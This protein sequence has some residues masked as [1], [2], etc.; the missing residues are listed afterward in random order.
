MKYT[1]LR[2]SLSTSLY[3]HLFN[4]LASASPCV[5][6]QSV[7][8]SSPPEFI[9]CHPHS[10]FQS[11]ILKSHR[12]N[13]FQFPPKHAPCLPGRS[14]FR[15]PLFVSLTQK[16]FFLFSFFL[17]FFLSFFD[18]SLSHDGGGRVHPDG[19]GPWSK[20]ISLWHVQVCRIA[21]RVPMPAARESPA[22]PNQWFWGAPVVRALSPAYV[23]PLTVFPSILWRKW[24][25]FDTTAAV[26]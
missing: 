14:T 22:G 17:F 16:P 18:L 5:L 25:S 8:L 21:S 15:C 20:M 9:P 23:V 2:E 1:C 11:V 3:F 6:K 10:L 4:G 7:D 24:L 19:T 26:R 13:A 12:F